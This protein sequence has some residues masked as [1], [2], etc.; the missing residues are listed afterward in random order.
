[1]LQ[2]NVAIVYT[3]SSPLFYSPEFEAIRDRAVFLPNVKLHER[4]R[5]DERDAEGYRTM[6]TFV[7]RR[8]R[9]D[10]IAR[11]ALEEAIHISGGVFR[12]MCRVMRYAIGRARV[13]GQPQVELEDV[14]R[15]G[16]EIR[17]EYRRI[18]T[19]AQ[20]Q[21]L[22]DVHT[23]NR[24]DRPDELGP[25]MQILAALEYRNDENWCDAHPALVP[26]LGEGR[27]TRGSRAGIPTRE[28]G[29]REEREAETG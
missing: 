22:L 11:D 17:N 20:R 1:M 27:G 21:L 14:Q 29:T 4:R 16:A 25:L 23:H 26:L 7:H 6:R 8:M 13:R 5:P 28:Q 10:L 3:V 15:A 24:L 9:P 19:A 18:L 2:P 12:E